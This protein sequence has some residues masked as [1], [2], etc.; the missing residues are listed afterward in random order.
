MTPKGLQIDLMKRNNIRVTC[1]T[2]LDLI[3]N[4]N[5]LTVA[6]TRSLLDSEVAGDQTCPISED[7][8]AFRNLRACTHFDEK[9]H[10]IRCCG[11]TSALMKDVPVKCPDCF[12]AHFRVRIE[13]VA[14]QVR[15]VT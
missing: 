11:V 1:I 15:D 2:R 4:I 3:I 13:Q 6:P 9:R 12:L 5:M 14:Q 10:D 8:T 7:I